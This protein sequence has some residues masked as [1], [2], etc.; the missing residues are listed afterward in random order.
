MAED[1]L[2][3]PFSNQSSPLLR[4]EGSPGL[5]RRQ[6]TGQETQS[7]EVPGKM[8]HMTCRN[9]AT[10]RCIYPEPECLYAHEMTGIIA[11]EPKRVEP[12][13]RFDR[14]LKL[15]IRINHR[16]DLAVA[17]EDVLSSRPNY[18]NCQSQTRSNS[19]RTGETPAQRS[20]N[21]PPVPLSNQETSP[22]T[23]KRGHR[24]VIS[25]EVLHSHARL[26][27]STR[28]ARSLIEGSTYIPPFDQHS[29]SVKSQNPTQGSPTPLRQGVFTNTSKDMIHD[30]IIHPHHSTRHLRSSFAATTFYTPDPLF[31]PD[32]ANM[33]MPESQPY[34][35]NHP[36]ARQIALLLAKLAEIN[37]GIRSR[38]S[39]LSPLM[40]QKRYLDQQ[41]GH[42]E[43][44]MAKRIIE[45]VLTINH[46]VTLE[47]AKAR[48]VEQALY[49]LGLTELPEDEEDERFKAEQGEKWGK[50]WHIRKGIDSDEFLTDED[51]HEN[52]SNAPKPNTMI[53]RGLLSQKAN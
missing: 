27:P 22:D 47:R 26:S 18:V 51:W 30:H 43:A 9:W 14:H 16:Q 1:A 35:M 8:K 29:I 37:Q 11:D 23:R 19:E 33:N 3:S 25:R 2:N 7:Q 31:A 13:S 50:G 42:A 36:N 46:E 6:D 10:G 53:E 4:R 12:R 41:M 39:C 40:K 21:I 38:R 49:A 28:L 17:G 5:R 32:F 24:R 20:H 15:E 45:R 34:S 44:Q 52:T 48:G